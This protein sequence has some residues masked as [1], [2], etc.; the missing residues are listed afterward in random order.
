MTEQHPAVT[1]YERA[2]A[3]IPDCFDH[4]TGGTIRETSEVAAEGKPWTYPKKEADAFVAAHFSMLDKWHDAI[5]ELDSEL[6]GNVVAGGLPDDQ[7]LYLKQQALALFDATTAL[8][9]AVAEYHHGTAGPALDPAYGHAYA[10]SN[11]AL[12]P[13]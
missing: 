13:F 8:L 5:D 10:L 4:L 7:A 6:R 1:A 9:R 2:T 11:S 3:G 12:R